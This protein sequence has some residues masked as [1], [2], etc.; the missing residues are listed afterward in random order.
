[1]RWLGRYLE[2]NSPTLEQ[3]AKGRLQPRRA[4]RS[5]SY[6]RLMCRLRL[7][8]LRIDVEPDATTSC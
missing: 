8:R 3:F 4:Q 2:E 7:I 5:G 1:M 6:S